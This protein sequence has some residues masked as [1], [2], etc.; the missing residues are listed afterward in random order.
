MVEG[1]D[2]DVWAAQHQDGARSRRFPVDLSLMSALLDRWRPETHTFHFRWGEM[3][4]TL[5]DVACL[6]GLPLAGDAIGPSEPAADWDLDLAA[7]FFN[8][9]PGGVHVEDVRQADRKGP[10]TQWLAQLEV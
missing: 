8:M 10:R 9:L 6:L 3:T 5:Q 7:R 2:E 4:V 1:T